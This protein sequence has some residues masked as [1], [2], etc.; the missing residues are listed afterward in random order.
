MS[1]ARKYTLEIYLCK[2]TQCNAVDPDV[3]NTIQYAKD[4][5]QEFYI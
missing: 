3:K 2:A 4:S 1:D 5:T